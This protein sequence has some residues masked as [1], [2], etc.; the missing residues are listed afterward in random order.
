L[1]R[2][3]FE[4]PCRIIELERRAPPDEREFRDK[5]FGKRPV[6]LTGQTQGLPCGAWT[7]EHIADAFGDLEVL[8]TPCAGPGTHFFRVEWT[9]KVK[10]TM[11]DALGRLARGED[12]RV[13]LNAKPKDMRRD[14][15]LARFSDDVIRSARYRLGRLHSVNTFFSMSHLSWGVH[16]DL[17]KEQMLMQLVG[18][19]AVV[20]FDDDWHNTRSLYPVRDYKEAFRSA[21]MDVDDVDLD[22][23]PRFSEATAHVGILEPGDAVYMPRAWWHDTRPLGLSLSINLRCFDWVMGT[24]KATEAAA[25]GLV[26]GVAPPKRSGTHSS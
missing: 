5:Y 21:I 9:E 13:Q 19:K 22:R 23:F 14:P 24:W 12:G 25:M 6:I 8:W 16:H 4:P 7:L 11:R 18:R 3:K 26:Y 17:G 1:R 15:T 2:D 10:T 20:L